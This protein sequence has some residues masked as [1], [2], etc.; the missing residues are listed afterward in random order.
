MYLVGIIIVVLIGIYYYYFMKKD[1]LDSSEG[2]EGGKSKKSK[3]SK[4]SRLNDESEASDSED[5]ESESSEYEDDESESSEYEEVESESSDSEDD[6]S[7]NDNYDYSPDGK[8]KFGYTGQLIYKGNAGT[9][10]IPSKNIGDNVEAYDFT[11]VINSY[12]SI[13]YFS[14]YDETF[15][16]IKSKKFLILGETIGGYLNSVTYEINNKDQGSGNECSWLHLLIADDKG[17]IPLIRIPAN[18]TLSWSEGKEEF[19]GIK[20]NPYLNSKLYM[21]LEAPY[22][23]CSLFVKDFNI[24]LEFDTS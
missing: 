11:D 15:Y 4:K 19:A 2:G 7:E 5:D 6:E 22:P 1:K 10:L 24:E 9:S 13:Q 16:T 20:I 3:K 17:I 23:G 12:K 8:K 18:R 21:V 14:K